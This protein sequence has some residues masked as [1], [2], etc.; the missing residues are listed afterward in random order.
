MKDLEFLVERL[1]F[2]WVWGLIL[3]KEEHV[4]Y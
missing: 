3:E 1:V 4:L 2:G